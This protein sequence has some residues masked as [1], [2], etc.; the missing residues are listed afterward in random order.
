MGYTVLDPSIVT[1]PVC[2]KRWKDPAANDNINA[3]TAGLPGILAT[4]IRESQNEFWRKR[5]IPRICLA[6]YRCR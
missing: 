2:A 5:D 4:G 1:D 6:I 3:S